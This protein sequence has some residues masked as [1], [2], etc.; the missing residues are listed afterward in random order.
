MSHFFHF[1]YLLLFSGYFLYCAAVFILCLSLV[2]DV[3]FTSY[4][5]TG[6]MYILIYLLVMD[7][8]F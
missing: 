2:D 8:L 7:I 5:L 4:F 6:M 3:A 1:P